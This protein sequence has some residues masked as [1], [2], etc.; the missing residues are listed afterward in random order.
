MVKTD[1]TDSCEWVAPRTDHQPTKPVPA[2]YRK[3][4]DP[5]IADKDGEIPALKD[6]TTIGT[7]G[8]PKAFYQVDAE[9]ELVAAV[10]EADHAGEKLLILGRL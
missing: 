8:K 3:A 5:K 2:W 10:R 1:F 6:L 4:A 7:G 9:E